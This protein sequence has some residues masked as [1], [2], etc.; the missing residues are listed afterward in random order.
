MV[1]RGIS[2]LVSLGLVGIGAIAR[3]QAPPDWQLKTSDITPI[4][5]NQTFDSARQEQYQ[6]Q[7][8]LIQPN[9]FDPYR[10][11]VA[12]S[13]EAHWR[14]TL[15]ATGVL[16]PKENYVGEGLGTILAMAGDRELSI[17][18]RRILQQAMQVATQLYASDP[19]FY[20]ELGDRFDDILTTSPYSEWVAMALIA[21]LQA[22]PAESQ[23]W[24]DLVKIRF[25][26]G[27]NYLPLQ[28]ALKD[29]DSLLNPQPQPSLADWLDWQ[30]IPNQAQLY[31]LCRSNRAVLCTAVL[32]DRQGNWVKDGSG[33]DDPLWSVPLL[34]RSLHDLRWSFIRGHTPQGIYR[35]E[36]LMPRSPS[37]EFRAYG[38]FPL[39][40]LFLPFEFGVKTFIPPKI[41][42]LPD[43]LD[44]YQR[45][46]PPHWRDYFPMQES[47]WAGKLGRSLIRIHG[48]GEDLTFFGG[49]KRFP[50][51]YGWNPAIGCLS[52]LEI[53]DP[54]TGQLQ[55]AD[56]P[57]IL[58]ALN[59]A[60]GG[61]I[62]G[63]AIVVEVAGEEER[64][65]SVQEIQSVLAPP[66]IGEGGGSTPAIDSEKD[67]EPLGL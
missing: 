26:N 58:K 22:A 61:Q 50:E 6:K 9:R 30:I 62:E 29:A 5:Q 14:Q 4:P 7:F 60:G 49:N 17:P 34:A 8:D 57:K 16:E 65:I 25:P 24:V 51:T 48:S 38:Q 21:K 39:V 46:L 43:N 64:P 13:T 56:M 45:L 37:N 41:E 44:A 33:G 2:W 67:F 31:I 63:Y 42:Q 66:T 36:G 47:F 53:Y 59:R 55:R 18:Q 10:Y 3:G 40:K 52:A 35:I 20:R 23:P 15:W 11:P 1:I 27:G 32:K 12:D 19:S 54:K 28:V